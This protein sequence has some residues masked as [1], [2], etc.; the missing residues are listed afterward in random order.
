MLFLTFFNTIFA[1][2]EKQ[3][4][5][6]T[7]QSS[8]PSI[9]CKQAKAQI[10]I[11]K[12]TRRKSKRKRRRRKKKTFTLTQDLLF[13]LNVNNYSGKWSPVDI[14]TLPNQAIEGTTTAIQELR[15]VFQKAENDQR[16]RIAIYGDSHTAAELWSG[17]LRRIL[18]SKYGDGGHG[19]ILPAEVF[20]WYRGSDI[21]LC[22]SGGWASNFIGKRGGDDDQRLGFSGMYIESNNP[23]DFGWIQTTSSN[24][25]GKEVSTYEIFTMADNS[26][27]TL[28]VTIDDLPHLEIDTRAESTSMQ[29][30]RISVPKGSHRLQVRPKGNGHVR[31]LGISTEQDPNGVI[32]DAMG[33]NGRVASDLLKW[34]NNLFQEGLQHINPDLIILEYG[35]NEANETSLSLKRYRQTLEKTLRRVREY[36]PEAACLL[37]GPTDRVIFEEE[38]TFSVWKRE[39]QIADI[40]RELALAHNCSFWD[41]QQAMGGEASILSWYTHKPALAS[42]DLI[43]L[44]RAGYSRSADMLWAAI[45]EIL[46]LPR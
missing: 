40:Q 36:Q 29:V 39:K 45:Q 18:Q 44:T 33:I 32:I 46:P 17:Q 14:D 7:S 6:L 42:R 21:N 3:S 34:E 43:H 26:G 1:K 37:M 12:K 31:I 22:H 5:S 8:I 25:Q 19:F 30:H 20:P 4:I 23:E 9:T 35:T 16:I 27:G 41:W 10:K 28:E 11:A 15:N 38:R 24:P 2:P 13:E